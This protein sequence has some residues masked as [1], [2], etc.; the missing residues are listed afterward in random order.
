MN[1]VIVSK[2]GNEKQTHRFSLQ[3]NQSI[4]IGRAWQN[5]IVLDDDFI[6]PEHAR[7][8]LD[9]NGVLSISDCDSC[10]GTFIKRKSVKVE[11]AVAFGAKIELGDASLQIYRATSQ[12]KPA[13][14]KDWASRLTNTLSAPVWLV[15]LTVMMLIGLSID[16]FFMTSGEQSDKAST[17]MWSIGCLLIW[18]VAAGFIGKIFRQKMQLMSHWVFTCLVLSIVTILS[19]AMAILN[20]NFQ[21]SW[22]ANI[23]EP[24]VIFGTLL[25]FVYGSLS[26]MSRL[27][28]FTKV[29][30][31]SLFVLLPLSAGYFSNSL[32][33]HQQKWRDSVVFENYNQPPALAFGKAKPVDQHLNSIDDLFA[34]ADKEVYML[35]QMQG[36]DMRVSDM[37]VLSKMQE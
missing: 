1:I 9:A 37:P 35:A 20:F 12:A 25:L 18:C 28:K 5:D 6:D 29:T 15:T 30:V 3:E 10:N 24:V 23:A 33:T 32:Q 27:G 34:K 14:K 26:L 21:A 31:A 36:K 4:T 13:L 11:G 7:I 16:T 8:T 17:F 2:N 19:W 22:V